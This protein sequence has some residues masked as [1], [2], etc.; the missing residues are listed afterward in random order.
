MN[1][2]KENAVSD[3]K[4]SGYAPIHQA[5]MTAGILGASHTPAPAKQPH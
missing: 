2:G 1:T 5:G 4:R 3:D